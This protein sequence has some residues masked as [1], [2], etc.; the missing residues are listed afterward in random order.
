MSAN[1]HILHQLAGTKTAAELAQKLGRHPEAMRRKLR[2]PV[3]LNIQSE[4]KELGYV[5]VW[6]DSFTFQIQRKHELPTAS[7]TSK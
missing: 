1:K 2:M 4:L 5:L 7:T 6:V 3:K